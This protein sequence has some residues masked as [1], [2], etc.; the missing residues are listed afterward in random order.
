MLY[1]TKEQYEE[2]RNKAF[3]NRV[4][5]SSYVVDLIF[6]KDKHTNTAVYNHAN[7]IN[8]GAKNPETTSSTAGIKKEESSLP[9]VNKPD[10]IVD[11]SMGKVK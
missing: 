1:L 5:M 4:T 3:A 7:T 11:F 2:I 10:N 8:R 9:K 6:P